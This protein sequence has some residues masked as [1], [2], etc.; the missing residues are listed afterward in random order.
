MSLCRQTVAFLMLLA[1][2][3]LVGA[4]C[5]AQ[6]ASSAE[7]D[8]DTLLQ[9]IDQNGSAL[10]S[11]HL[12]IY[13]EKTG[14][15]VDPPATEKRE[16]EFWAD[17][18]RARCDVRAAECRGTETT[19]WQYVKL[20]DGERTVETAPPDFD[21]AAVAHPTDLSEV[22]KYVGLDATL[23]LLGWPITS[24]LVQG[25][26]FASY[27]Q[28]LHSDLGF[29]SPRLVGQEQIGESQ[30]W[31]VAVTRR[32]AQGGELTKTLW[33]APARAYAPVRWE[34]GTSPCGG[35]CH[36]IV[37]E[38]EQWLQPLEGFWIPQEVTR[39]DY[40]QEGPGGQ[41]RLIA[42]VHCRLVSAAF[43]IPIGD[44]VFHV[45]LAEDATIYPR[46]W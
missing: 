27:L 4:Q 5:E 17:G 18:V 2:I 29:Q 11:A 22:C 34:E 33:V 9:R 46:R 23:G 12:L 8:V 38:A 6:P 43:N 28:Q 44:D 19:S 20:F 25:V 3:G 21:W 41:E 45:E 1:G 26:S 7:L 35:R 16:I 40:L 30:C 13:V 32:D 24:K 10:E 14:Y 31:S 36:H 42:E 39:R 37:D 15:R